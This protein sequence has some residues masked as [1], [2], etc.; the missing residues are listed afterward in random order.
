MRNVHQHDFF[1]DELPYTTVFHAGC[2]IFGGRGTPLPI[3]SRFW[4]SFRIFVPFFGEGFWSQTPKN[5]SNSHPL[6]LGVKRKPAPR[7]ATGK[8]A[9]LSS[10]SWWSVYA[11][12]CLWVEEVVLGVC[13]YVCVRVWVCVCVCVYVCVRVWVCVC[14]CVCVWVRVCMCV[15]VCVCVWVRVC[16]CVCV[17]VSDTVCFLRR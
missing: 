2:H 7:V 12:C 8:G 9:E 11:R 3:F 16:V 17:C 14:V 15:C 5:N 10:L 13:V 1:L 4:V 6:V